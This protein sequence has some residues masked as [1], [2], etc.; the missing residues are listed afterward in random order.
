MV[1]FKNLN[2]HI[3][4]TSVNVFEVREYFLLKWHIQMKQVQVESL[5]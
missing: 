1:L 5:I 2:L 3:W 4:S